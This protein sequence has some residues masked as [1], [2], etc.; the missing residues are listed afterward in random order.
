MSLVSTAYWYGWPAIYLVACMLAGVARRHA[1]AV[2]QGSAWLGLGVAVAAG[3][4]PLLNV[5]VAA[6]PIG[7]V[8]ANLVALLGWIIV[9]FSEP[10]LDGE[11]EQ[12]R[13]V[14]AFLLTLASV[15][16][17]IITSHLVLLVA[18]WTASSLGLHRLLTFHRAR[19]SAQIVAHK[20]FLA[21]RMAE[22][23]LLGALILIGRSAGT[24]DMFEIAAYVHQAAAVPP[25]LQ[26]A[27]V[28]IALAAIL[29][30]AQLPIHGWLIQV[31]EAPTPVSALLHAGVVN[32]GGF[33]L[34][35]LAALM[36]AAPAA[37]AVLVVVGSLTAVLAGLVMMTRISI[38]VRLAWS[39]C[40]Q[41]GFMLMECGLGLYELA[42]LHLVAHSL[43]KAHAFLTAGETVLHA[44]EHDLVA[45]HSTHGPRGRVAYRLL[46]LPISVA[47]VAA[48]AAVWRR[49]V[50]D[51]DL[52]SLAIAVVGLGLAPLLWTPD[53]RGLARGA[54]R[55]L[56][57]A[58]LYLLWHVGAAQVAPAFAPPSVALTIWAAAALGVL[59]V[60]QTWVVAFPLG[61][62]STKLYPW[63]Y[64][65]FFLDER[66]TR[67]TFRV[68]PA[69]VPPS[70]SVA[71]QE[72]RRFFG[73][74]GS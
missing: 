64:A 1:W 48:S 54:L 45:T 73:G 38:K 33:V 18:A 21:S 36:A 16:T 22:I 55:V 8:M 44:R 27:A 74:A 25:G 72:L 24:L 6:D 7:A 61:K 26:V 12:D 47:L 9:R 31:M 30:S 60:V 46:V 66:F 57:L 70:P 52:P 28:L 32:I 17:L 13:Y 39:T 62:L 59:Y 3:L 58:Q 49:F 34:I 42:M 41:M 65:G 51:M 63:A 56:G 5:P 15:A 37:R 4:A 11:P 68:W 23:C 40:A 71:E 35:R 10:Y 67:L 20:K 14:T 69:R 53:P 2:A 29:K 50:P 43:Y 19:A